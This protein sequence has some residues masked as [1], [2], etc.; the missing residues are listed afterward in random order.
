MGYPWPGSTPPLVGSAPCGQSWPIPSR[1]FSSLKGIL[2]S[3]QFVLHKKKTTRKQMTAVSLWLW[4]LPTAHLRTISPSRSSRT[5]KP[6]MWRP[7]DPQRKPYLL[8]LFGRSN[9][10]FP[11]LFFFNLYFFLFSGCPTHQHRDLTLCQFHPQ[12]LYQPDHGDAQ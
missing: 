10:T 1:T 5:M 9:H 12:R 4:W 8:Y 6:Q 3:Y 11:V 2:Y 7:V